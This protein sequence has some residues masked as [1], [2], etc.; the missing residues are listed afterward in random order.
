MVETAPDEPREKIARLLTEF[1]WRL[2]EESGKGVAELFTQDARVDTPHFQ[3]AGRS[4]IEA[5]FGGRTATK[6]TRH[7][8]SNL[9]VTPLGPDHFLVTSN[10]INAAGT[11]PAPQPPEKVAFAT[12]KDEIV[13]RDG[14]ALFGSRTLEI[15]F[16][17]ALPAPDAAT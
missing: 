12:A 1:C 2:D 4:E 17:M 15:L 6:L 14:V 9:R 8:W 11:L 16:E 3:L 5:W 13:L 10:M 7:N